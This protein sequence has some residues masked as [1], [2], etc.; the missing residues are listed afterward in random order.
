MSEPPPLPHAT[1]PA[2]DE[3]AVPG[4]VSVARGEPP[5]GAEP[6]DDTAARA[7][8][9]RCRNC[10]ANML[11]D[12]SVDALSCGHCGHVEAVPRLEGTIVERTLEEAGTAARGFGLAT[13]A[14][15]CTRC[16]AKTD[17]SG[18]EVS[19]TCAFCGAPA[20]LEESSYRNALRPESLIPLDLARGEV[21]QAF[22]RWTHGL[23]FRPSTLRHARV[24][25]ARGVY[26]PAWT[27]DA[28]VWSQWSADAGWYYTVMEPR[29]VMVQG[30]LQ[31]RMVPVRKVRWEP[32]FGERRDVF[33]DLLVHASRGLS[34]K[35]VSEL[36]GFPTQGLVPYRPEYLSGWGAEEYAVDL[37][38]A[39]TD[40]L[41]SI[42][43]RQTARC[44]GDVPGDTQRN[45]RV[46]NTV[47]EVRWKLVLLPVW[48]VTYRHGGRDWAVLVHGT[49]GRVAG[50]AP[51]SG[52]KIALVVLAI[53]L[54][55]LAFLALAGR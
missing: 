24:D 30:K 18:Q 41:R 35:L 25:Q 39:W 47:S 10:G 55:A 21:E 52:V 40:A 2:P 33:D 37:E 17:F 7:V 15:A 42:E 38:A 1:P 28:R 53:G 11:W 34:P 16:G 19:T 36:G 14:A 27:F 3:P 44:A 8:Q 50:D 5:A 45:L 49:T 20:V 4:R 31:V 54:A 43:A 6:A 9:V 46:R 13:R 32:R 22:R 51:Y 29:P 48:S 12:P 23:W 26:V